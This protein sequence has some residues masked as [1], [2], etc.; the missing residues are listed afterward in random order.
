MD[1]SKLSDSDLAALQKGD[2]GSISDAGLSLLSSASK[3][4]L[5]KLENFGM[6]ALKGA[7]NIGSTILGAAAPVVNALGGNM[8][9]GDERRKQLGQFFQENADPE[10]LAFK[11][12]ELGSEIAGTAGIGGVL[13]KPIV[14]A[15]RYAPALRG[16]AQSVETAGFQAPNVASRIAGGAAVGG[17]AAG[18][19]NPDDAAV[20][21][22]FGGTLGAVAPAV[23]KMLSKPA[24]ASLLRENPQIIGA[25]ASLTADEAVQKVAADL[26]VTAADLPPSTV[27]FVRDETL[28]AFNQGK[29]I[30]PA[31]LLRKQDFEALGIKPMTGQITRDPTQ[32]AMERNLRGVSP[33]IQ[34]TITEQNR[35]MQS[36]FGKPAAGAKEPYQAGRGLVDALRASD[37]EQRKGVSALYKQARESAGKDLEVPMSGLANDYVTVLDEFGDKVPSGV[38]NQFKKFGLEGAEQKKLFTVEEADKVLKVINDNVGADRATNTALSRL[39]DAVKN[40]VMEVADDG[41]VFAPA[42]KA[43]KERFAKLDAIP[44]LKAVAEGNASP[45]TFVKKFILQGNTDEVNRL[46]RTLDSES[47]AQAKSQVADDIRRAAFGENVAGDAALRPE[48]LAKKLREIGT[49]KLKAFFSPEEVD[50]Y[51]TALRVATYIEKH[52]NAA[53]VNTSNTLVASLMTNPA[54]QLVGKAAKMI[55]GAELATNVV[56]GVARVAKQQGQVKSALQAKVPTSNLALSESQQK[57]LAKA[58]GR[59]S[60][61][62]SSQTGE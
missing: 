41:G 58:L 37:E 9:S 46:A 7:S 12:G 27:Q 57:L 1:L 49:D 21:A 13:A 60:A 6:G 2:V 38:R 44:A 34:G 18:L 55:P 20:G 4:K 50:R 31:A 42:V 16:V 36:V 54:T 19:V 29:K 39:R 47:L 23:T 35:V 51:Q 48:M 59:T 61:G 11:G 56:G 25:R 62:V 24:G 30:D 40:S 28:K 14:A 43:A 17:G 5:N 45:D 15:S 26:G 3:P 32:F 22:A 8:M 53:P 33:E 52:P 10:S